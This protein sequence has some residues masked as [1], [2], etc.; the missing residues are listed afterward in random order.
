MDFNVEFLSFLYVFIV[1]VLGATLQGSVGFGLG[2][3]AVPLLAVADPRYLP[4]P[5][6]LA[7][8]V[9]TI[10]LSW[11]EHESIQVKGMTWVLVGRLVGALIGVRLLVLILIP[12]I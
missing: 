2:F 6:L 9:L 5:L 3:V 8:L 1:S 12:F 11:R 4:G 7:A 10:L